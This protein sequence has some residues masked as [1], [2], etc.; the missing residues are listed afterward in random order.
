MVEAATKARRSVDRSDYDNKQLR[1]FNFIIANAIFHELCH[2]FSSFLTKDRTFTP[3]HLTAQI[4][5]YVEQ[6]R[7]EAGRYMETTLFGGTLEY[8]R[9]LNHGDRQVRLD[10]LDSV[11]QQLY[12]LRTK[13]M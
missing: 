1:T 8:F 5:G 9:G 7:G 2:L 6:H 3:R 13:H 10:G 4:E 11:I 12:V